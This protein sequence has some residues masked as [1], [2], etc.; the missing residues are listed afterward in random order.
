VNGSIGSAGGVTAQSGAT[1]G[2]TGS[3]TGPVTV[4]AGAA[5]SPGI[6]ILWPPP[7]HLTVN[8]TLALGAGSTT[9][10]QLSKT[11][12]TNDQVRGITTVAYGGTLVVTNLAG[13]LAAGD[14]FKLFD[15]AH[16]TGAFAAISPASPGIGS[17]W[18]MSY[19]PVDGTLRVV[20][21]SSTQCVT[22]AGLQH[23]ALSNATLNLEPIS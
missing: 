17:T 10:M 1:L 20:S 11:A 14:S 21:S 2:G 15:A 5:L 8:N 16:Y 12:G 19:L 23:C 7:T 4:Q 9:I 22:F 6:G 3:I 18:D 13:T